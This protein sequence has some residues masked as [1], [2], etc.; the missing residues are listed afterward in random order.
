MQEGLPELVFPVEA[1]QAHYLTLMTA[2]CGWR[3]PTPTHQEAR[4]LTP[5]SPPATAGGALTRY[6]LVV[7]EG[8]GVQLGEGRAPHPTPPPSSGVGV[9]DE[10]AGACLPINS[11]PTDDTRPPQHE[12]LVHLA[13]TLMDVGVDD[14]VG[15]VDAAVGV[16]DTVGGPDVVVCV[17]SSRAA[18]L[19]RTCR[20]SGYKKVNNQL[21]R[22]SQL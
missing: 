13:D 20:W 15:G 11:T 5:T 18:S 7:G 4:P 10:G 14:A 16:D 9:Q 8:E 21:S 2:P 17:D 6:G 12:V 1:D 3:P 22:S 19:T